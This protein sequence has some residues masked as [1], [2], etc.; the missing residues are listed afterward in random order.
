M[1]SIELEFIELAF[2][3]IWNEPVHRVQIPYK[4]N[5]HGP[6]L[7][8]FWKKEKRPTFAQFMIMLLN[9]NQWCKKWPITYTF[10]GISYFDNP[11]LSFLLY[12]LSLVFLL[13]SKI[14][15]ELY[16]G[17][18]PNISWFLA[19]KAHCLGLDLNG[20]LTR[21]NFYTFQVC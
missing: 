15:N 3:L 9:K 10:S 4:T 19:P 7:N 14:T 18:G 8:G 2:F 17:G 16:T 6:S 21:R 5:K 1:F 13:I 11:W 20:L 12:N